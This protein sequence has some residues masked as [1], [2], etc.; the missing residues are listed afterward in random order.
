MLKLM[1]SLIFLAT[2]SLQ[3]N[4]TNADGS[5]NKHH[6][7]DDPARELE[8]WESLER[9]KLSG[10]EITSQRM[11][12][13]CCS[14]RQGITVYKGSTPVLGDV[15]VKV[16][17]SDCPL[18]VLQLQ[19]PDGWFKCVVSDRLESEWSLPQVSGPWSLRLRP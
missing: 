3:C 16:L 11:S 12:N 9:F 13:A 8:V 19:V 2:V 1:A 6:H 15:V 18:G 7:D 14:G 10:S 4:V 17:Q 5:S